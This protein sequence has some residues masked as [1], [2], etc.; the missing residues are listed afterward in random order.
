MSI[1]VIMILHMTLALRYL[2]KRLEGLEVL[3]RLLVN[4][5]N[6]A[7]IL[8]FSGHENVIDI[9]EVDLGSRRGGFLILGSGS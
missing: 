4:L 3:H 8:E 5:V 2:E 9:D 7:L 1:L 6:L